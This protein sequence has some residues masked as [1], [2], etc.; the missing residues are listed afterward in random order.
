MEQLPESNLLT[1]KQTFVF[2]HS[3][4]E[5]Q[6]RILLFTI[7]IMISAPYTFHVKVIDDIQLLQVISFL[8]LFY[9]QFSPNNK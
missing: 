6:R 1:I 7:K 5:F 4:Q 2:N 3:K 9:V 8:L